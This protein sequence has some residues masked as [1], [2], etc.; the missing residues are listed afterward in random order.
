MKLKICFKMRQTEEEGG[1]ERQKNS[2]GEG[3]GGVLRLN[4]ADLNAGLGGL[5]IL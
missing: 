4:V 3:G 1:R 5:L 2:E